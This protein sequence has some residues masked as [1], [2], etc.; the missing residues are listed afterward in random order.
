MPKS[1][2][3]E[4]KKNKYFKKIKADFICLN[5]S[6]DVHNV[7]ILC[8]AGA[9]IFS[10]PKLENIE[11]RDI[12]NLYSL[13]SLNFVTPRRVFPNFCWLRTSPN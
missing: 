5:C 3:A 1:D 9:S 8:V 4:S 13:R 2:N 12:T 11:H 7:H 6:T 10:S